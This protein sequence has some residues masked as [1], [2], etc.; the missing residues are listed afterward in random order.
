MVSSV[1]P[2]FTD[3]TPYQPDLTAM[4]A[5][6]KKK[7]LFLGTTP[8]V[9]SAY[10]ADPYTKI[11]NSLLA[12]GSSTAPAAG[13]IGEGIARALSGISGGLFAKDAREKYIGPDQQ[14]QAAILTARN[15]EIMNALNAGQSPPSTI[16][17]DPSLTQPTTPPPVT[18]TPPPSVVSALGGPQG[19][20]SPVAANPTPALPGSTGGANLQMPPSQP[21]GPLNPGPANYLAPSTQTTGPIRPVNPDAAFRAV[22]PPAG[23]VRVPKG[24]PAVALAG[25]N[26]GGINDGGFA[27][28][29]PGYVGNNGRYAAFD[30][31]AN[32]ARAQATLL[33]SYVARGFDTPN[34]I[35]A[36]WAP[37]KDGNDPVAYAARMA[38]NLGIGPDDK[39]TPDMLSRAQ[40]A[41]AKVENSKSVPVVGQKDVAGIST[42]MPTVQPQPVPELPA[43]QAQPVAPMLQDR[44]R[45]ARLAV[46]HNLISQNPNMDP[47]L[48]GSIVD[49]EYQTGMEEDM[50]SKMQ[51]DQQLAEMAKTGYEG[52]IQGVNQNNQAITQGQVLDHTNTV[53]GNIDLAKQG[54]VGHQ[55]QALEAQKNIGAA[56]IQSMQDATTLR[57][58]QIKADAVKPSQFILKE[59][60]QH[61]ATLHDTDRIRQLVN[62]RPK[63]VGLQYSLTDNLANQRFDPEGEDARAA[64]AQ[65]AAALLQKTSGSA[66]TPEEYKRNANWLPSPGDTA[67]TINKKLAGIDST[68]RNRI[69][70]LH[71]MPGASGVLAGQ[72]NITINQG[73]PAAPAAA[74]S[75]KVPNPLLVVH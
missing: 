13:G 75:G 33:K 7:G 14:A 28:K 60:E 39:I 50:K 58:E 34:K 64:I 9:A 5:A 8:A 71:S 2:N 15:P 51:R 67:Q 23:P 42:A 20:A 12:S 22:S 72:P 52:A 56:N 16:N 57:G 35:A 65:L 41:Q 6:A 38:K 73:A 19:P 66:V 26:P 27:A 74:S 43:T 4:L 29:Q 25:N 1:T 68:A 55:Q 49:P 47:A 69:D 10:N 24:Q 53:A 18:G 3:Y 45:S 11:A 30:T 46:A 61:T 63:S 17:I 70:I 62:A 54:F 21:S 37:V 59:L 44:V 40:L 48:L 36:R 32:G 31:P